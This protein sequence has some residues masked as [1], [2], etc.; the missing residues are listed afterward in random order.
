MFSLR[1]A[2]V[3]AMF[4][5]IAV[6]GDSGPLMC[7][8]TQSLPSVVTPIRSADVAAQVEG[9]VD[10]LFIQEGD[11]VVAGQSLARINDQ[12]PQAQVDVAQAAAD[13]EAGLQLAQSEL[14][15][16][17][18]ILVRMRKALERRA[19][20]PAECDRTESECEL[21]EGRLLRAKEQCRQRQMELKLERA[22]LQAHRLV[23]P[24]DGNVLRIDLH[25]GNT[26]RQGISVLKIADLTRLRAVVFVPFEWFDEMSC[27]QTVYVTASAPVHRLLEARVVS[28][29]PVIDAATET[30]RCVLEI[31]NRDGSLPSGFSIVL[32][33]QH[34]ARTEVAVKQTDSLRLPRTR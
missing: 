6:P 28:V 31:D 12:I 20:S 24:F 8:T 25:V 27:G 2:A 3:M 32:E 23:A 19:I 22:R 17:R 1:S 14:R 26:V 18:R 10:R 21:A 13:C 30:F 7:S 15:Q 33:R 9:D 29:E 16:A 11:A 5:A 34:I 4:A